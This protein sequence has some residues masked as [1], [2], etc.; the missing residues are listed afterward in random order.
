MAFTAMLS[1]LYRDLRDGR[2][3]V[4]TSWAIRPAMQRRSDD[5]AVGEHVRSQGRGPRKPGNAAA[6][7]TQVAICASSS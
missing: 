4:S 2:M 3:R 7:F 1:E 5:G 6:C